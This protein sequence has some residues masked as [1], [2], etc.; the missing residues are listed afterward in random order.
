[1]DTGRGEAAMNNAFIISFTEKGKLLADGLAEKIKAAYNEANV[2]ADRVSGLF[3]YVKPIFITGNVLIFIGAAGIAI[4][5][6]APYIKSKGTDPAVLV[7]DEYARFVIPI[8]SGH[9]GGAYDYARKIADL[10]K[11]TP[12][13]TSARDAGIFHVG[14]GAK[15]NTDINALENFFFE[16]LNSLFIPIQ[17][18]AS[19]SSIDLK[20]NEKAITALCEKYSIRYITYTSEELNSV[21]DIFGLSEFVKETTGTGNVCEAAA[22]L[23]SKNGIMVLPKT[24]KSGATLAIAKE[25]WRVSSVETDN[26]RA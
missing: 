16:T 18:V 12:V 9:E 8:L 13:I 22:Y 20:K 24:A 21:A 11:A 15:K 1:M 14:I 7:I 5:A 3:E 23:S 10:I 2:T 17:A 19:I 6:I 4:R 26:D 25:L